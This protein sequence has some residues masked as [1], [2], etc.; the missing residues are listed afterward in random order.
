[1]AA[2]R[3]ERLEQVVLCGAG[4]FL[5]CGSWFGVSGL[6]KDPLTT[7]IATMIPLLCGLLLGWLSLWIVVKLMPEKK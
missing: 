7:T 1:M 4:W 5:R 3:D 2:D 6:G